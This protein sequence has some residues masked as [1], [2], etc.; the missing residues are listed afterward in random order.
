MEL[1]CFGGVEY[2]VE[3]LMDVCLLQV[4]FGYLWGGI[5]TPTTPTI[6]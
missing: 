3:G 2:E 1:G 6:I 5:F 4:V